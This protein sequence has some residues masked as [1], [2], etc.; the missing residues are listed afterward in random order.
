MKMVLGFG[1]GWGRA[2]GDQAK[3]VPPPWADFSVWGPQTGCP[4]RSLLGQ[5]TFPRLPPSRCGLDGRNLG[6]L[7]LPSRGRRKGRVCTGPGTAPDRAAL[8]PRR[9]GPP[10]S[11]AWPTGPVASSPRLRSP[12]PTPTP[13]SAEGSPLSAA[14]RASHG[15]HLC[16]CCWRSVAQPCPALRP[17]L[18]PLVESCPLSLSFNFLVCQAGGLIGSDLRQL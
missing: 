11:Q 9:P 5:P 17:Q 16:G 3:L 1:R 4:Q 12:S 8:S 7:S 6:P 14:W 2:R 15:H 18:L 10:G 13:I